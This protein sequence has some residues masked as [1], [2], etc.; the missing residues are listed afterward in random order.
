MGWSSITESVILSVGGE[1]SAEFDESTEGPDPR[2]VPF[3]PEGMRP[4]RRSGKVATAR[5]VPRAWSPLED[6]GRCE[7]TSE[8]TPNSKSV[9]RTRPVD[10]QFC[11]VSLQ[12][13]AR[14]CSATD[15]YGQPHGLASDTGSTSWRRPYRVQYHIWT[16]FLGRETNSGKTFFPSPPADPL[17][18]VVPIVLRSGCGVA[19]SGLYSA[20]GWNS[21]STKCLWLVISGRRVVWQGVCIGHH[22]GRAVFGFALPL[23]TREVGPRGSRNHWGILPYAPLRHRPQQAL[24]GESRGATG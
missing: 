15:P 18:L 22:F 14:R 7:A 13:Q 20:D 23:A 16:T 9:R 4:R 10:Y 6:V 19:I 24:L 11:N 5:R 12:R 17:L 1:A 3:E 8:S 21:R 2:G